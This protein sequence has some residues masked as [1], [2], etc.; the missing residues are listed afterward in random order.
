ML[1][2]GVPG[3]AAAQNQVQ[4]A[5]Q[6]QNKDQPIHIEATTL[7]IQDK[8]KT[9]TFSGNVQVVQGDTT[10]RCRSL[11]VFYGPE[12]GAGATKAG[13]TPT[14]A[15]SQAGPGMPQ[16]GQSIRRVEARGDVTVV[17]KDHNA[18]GD[19]GVYDMT[20]KTVTLTGNVVVSQGKNVLHGERVVV[21]TVT[22][23]ARVDSGVM[24]HDRV[25]SG[26]TAHDRVRVLILPAKDAKGA[27]TNIMSFG[28]PSPP[29]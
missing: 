10:M 29:N 22:G 2:L 16:G 27:P 19:L 8:I 25:E 13:A 6:G 11:V 24:A 20:T 4:G 23:D 21:D 3:A 17:T 7:E 15:E 9:A 12:E 5:L 1:A 18:S 14:S 26:V 28:A